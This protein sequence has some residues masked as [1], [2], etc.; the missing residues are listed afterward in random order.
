MQSAKQGG[1]ITVV[2]RQISLSPYGVAQIKKASCPKRHS[3]IDNDFKIDGLA[4]LKVKVISDGNEGIVHLDPV[5]GK[6][7]NHFDVGFEI[8]NDA[9]FVCPECSNSLIQVN[10]TCPE[11]GSPVLAFEVNG[12]GI[13]E[14]CSSEK[15]NWEKWDFVDSAGL[16]EFVEI[17]VSDTGCGISKKIIFRKFLNHFFQQKDKKEPDLVLRLFGKLLITIT[18]RLQLIVK[19]VKAQ[20]YYTSSTFSRN[21]LKMS[22]TSDILVIDDEQVVIDAVIKIC[23]LENYSVDA[24]LNVKAAIEKITKNHYAIII[25]DIMIPDGDGFHILDELGKQKY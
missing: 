25:C 19:W 14:V 11:C 22:K 15:S 7:R 24:A 5:Y 17:K 21:S 10:K 9:E 12:K 2:S 6:H 16:K 3:L 1:T 20:L 4:T 23:A 13:Y 18:E 8:K